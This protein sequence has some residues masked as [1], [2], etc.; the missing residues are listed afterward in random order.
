MMEFCLVKRNLLI[1]KVYPPEAD[2]DV[3]VDLQLC[4]VIEESL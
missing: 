2:D 4:I 3:I 1:F